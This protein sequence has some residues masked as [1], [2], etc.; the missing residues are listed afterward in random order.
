MKT[1][2]FLPIV[3]LILSIS[4]V[5]AQNSTIEATVRNLT[6]HPV[7]AF[8]VDQLTIQGMTEKDTLFIKTSQ[9]FVFKKDDKDEKIGGYQVFLESVFRHPFFNVDAVTHHFYDGDSL[10]FDVYSTKEVSRHITPKEKLKNSNFSFV[11][12]SLPTLLNILE[13]KGFRTTLNKDTLLN[14]KTYLYIKAFPEANTVS[15]ELLIDKQQNLPYFL[16]ITINTFQPFIDEFTYSSFAYPDSFEKPQSM[17]QPIQG[18]TLPVLPLAV[19]DF[20]PDWDL[21]LLSGESF[22]FRKLAGKKTILYVSMINCGPCQ[23]AIPFVQEL[24]EKYKADP[25]IQVVVFYPYDSK[26]NLDKYVKTKQISYPIVYNSMES[27]NE[28]VEIMNKME[29]GM[30]TFLL[31]DKN[32]KISGSITGFSNNNKSKI[33]ELIEEKLKEISLSR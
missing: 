24:I 10:I 21:R 6:K 7:V 28:R 8:H 13:S 4:G 32:K 19:G 17:L 33:E 16:R 14:G 30:P 25:D 26:T 18:A 31:L 5:N 20:V 29:L 27:E 9:N 11:N 12:G 2:N 3:L 22:S 23:S 15:H 1:K